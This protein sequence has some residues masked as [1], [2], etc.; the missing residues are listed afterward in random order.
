[1]IPR[2]YRERVRLRHHLRRYAI[3]LAALLLVG[4]GAAGLLRW[5]V[6]TLD[7]D[8]QR[9]RRET[10]RT[11]AAATLLDTARTRATLLEHSTAVLA[12]LRGAGD[13]QRIADGF[14][15]A[16]PPQVW[17]RQL[18]LVRDAQALTASPAAPLPGDLELPAIPGKP[19][20]P[21][22]RIA[23]TVQLR[24]QATD[25]TALAAF[26][27]ALGEQPAFS[28]VSLT[29]SSATL[30]TDTIDFDAVATLRRTGVATP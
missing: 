8:L 29:G 5:R 18:R 7:T 15:A 16:M 4:V 11:Q 10:S 30:G 27:R 2:S 14:D 25:Y 9:L 13:L 19:A 12:A 1:M 24:G 20:P 28:Q 22:W 23:T 26:L 21:P 6:A 17:L 3:A